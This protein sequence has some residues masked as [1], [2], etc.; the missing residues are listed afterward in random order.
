MNE[1]AT[2]ALCEVGV[3]HPSWLQVT[4]WPAAFSLLQ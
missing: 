3:E 1:A 2:V 4:G